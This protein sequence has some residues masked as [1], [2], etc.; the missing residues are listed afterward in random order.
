MSQTFKVFSELLSYPSEDMQKAADEMKE[1]IASEK[2]LSPKHLKEVEKFIDHIAQ[3]DIYDLQEHYVDMFD[4]TREL[5]LHLFEHIHGESKSRGQALVSLGQL[6]EQYDIVSYTNELPD[7]LPLFLEF[8]SVVPEDKAQ[9]TLVEPLA[10]FKVLTERLKEKK[11]SYAVVLD[12][13]TE[14]AQN[15]AKNLSVAKQH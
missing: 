10:I 8:L 2:L 7:Y 11:S 12:A 1:V 14:V 15:H 5:S 3:T 4:R 6:Y 13:L 9:N